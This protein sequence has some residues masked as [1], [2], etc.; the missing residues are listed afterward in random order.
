MDI[1]DC[2]IIGAGPAGIFAA[3]N[4]SLKGHKVLI[5]EKKSSPGR[6]FLISGSGQCNITNSYREVDFYLNY[7]EKKNFTKKIINR[8]SPDDLLKF[9]KKRGIDFITKENGKVFPASNRASDLLD[10][11]IKELKQLDITVIYDNKVESIKEKDNIF[12]IVANKNYL[13]RSVLI[14]TGGKSYPLTG[15][16]GDVESICKN[17]DVRLNNMIPALTPLY[18][19]NNHFR[20]LSGISTFVKIT[21]KNNKKEKYSFSGDLLFTH[22]GISGPVILRLSRYINERSELIISFSKLDQQEFEERFL[23]WTDKNGN[24]PILKLD[25]LSHL[26]ARLVETLLNMSEITKDTK[27]SQVNKRQRKKLI[28][29]IC[30]HNIKGFKKAGFEV[31]MITR[32]GVPTEELFTK[33]LMHKRHKGLFFT[34]EVIDVDADTGGYNLQFAFSS[35]YV[36]A[37]GVCDY[38]D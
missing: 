13:S 20:A 27:A 10:V 28:D 19:N 24:R 9:F 34:G 38:L 17:L 29:N 16:E 11:M 6:K 3:I 26:P 23:K 25:I 33:S 21:V 2:I 5:L 35:A 18:L 7:F 31:A 12:N 32:G 36:A 8:F 1:F 37:N 30:N 14:A 15:S 22:K 4:I